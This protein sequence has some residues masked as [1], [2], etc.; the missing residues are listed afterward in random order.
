MKRPDRDP[1]FACIACQT[2]HPD[3]LPIFLDLGPADRIERHALSD[4]SVELGGILLGKECVDP[5]TGEHFAWITRAIE[6]KHYDNTRASFTYTHDSW[7]EI[8]RERERLHPDLDIVGWYHTHPDF[9]I[10]LSHHDLFLHQNFFPQ[11]L[12]VAYVVDPIQGSRGFFRWSDGKMVQVEGFHLCAPRSERPALARLADDLENLP[13]DPESAGAFPSPRLEAE[14]IKMLNRPA[15]SSASNDRLP[16][17]AVLGFLGGLL[18]VIGLAAAIG[19]ALLHVRL[20]EQSETLAAV[21]QRV[22]DDSAGRR[23]ALDALREKIE[24][25]EP[26]RFVERYELAARE[27]DDAQRRLA[28]ERSIN[29][30]LAMRSKELQTRADALAADLET[31][32]VDLQKL[33]AEA[34]K[35]TALQKRLAELEQTAAE[36]KRELDAQRPIVESVEGERVEALLSSLN[37]HRLAA[38]AGG[39]VSVLL[40]LAAAFLYYRAIPTPENA[41]RQGY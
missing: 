12:Q 17:A 27:R 26:A 7:E 31:A 34:E 20:T 9:G 2:P 35:T 23:L 3:D 21:Q 1:R 37:L 10:F 41:P 29:E 22:D 16:T 15:H 11:P 18:G 30:T 38:Y 32:L 24:G 14:L 25:D 6:A 19:L 40:A 36:Q 39:L 8:T 13:R 28:A 4:T 33:E 5:T